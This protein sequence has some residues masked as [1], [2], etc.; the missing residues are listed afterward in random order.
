MS[1]VTLHRTAGTSSSERRLASN[2][3][4]YIAVAI[5]LNLVLNF[6]SSTLLPYQ[7]ALAVG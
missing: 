5:G 6:I 4:V 3:G 1:T 7:T 2:A